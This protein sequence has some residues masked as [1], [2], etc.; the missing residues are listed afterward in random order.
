MNRMWISRL[1]GLSDEGV[2]WMRGAIAAEGGGA[3]RHATRSPTLVQEIGALAGLYRTVFWMIGRKI[4]YGQV[5]PDEVYKVMPTASQIN[6]EE[7]ARTKELMGV[8]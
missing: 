8:R 6:E 7:E 3:M 5:W 1:T 2:G 4:Q